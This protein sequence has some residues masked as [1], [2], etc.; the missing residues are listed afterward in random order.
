VDAGDF[1]AVAEAFLLAG[2]WAWALRR[3]RVWVGWREKSALSALIC[4]TVAAL[5]DSMLILVLHSHSNSTSTGITFVIALVASLLLGMAGLVLG[6]LGKGIPRMAGTIW[7]AVTLLSV[8]VSVVEAHS[9][10][11]QL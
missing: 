10:I 11:Q 2:T 1:I 6:M 3:K 7:S 4:A 5:A 9:V 8:A